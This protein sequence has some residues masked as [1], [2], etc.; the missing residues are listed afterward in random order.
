[1]RIDCIT[2]R[3]KMIPLLCINNQTP[4]I[5]HFTNA[6][7]SESSPLRY[8]RIAVVV[9]ESKMANARAPDC[10]LF[11]I[12]CWIFRSFVQ[13]TIQKEKTPHRRDESVLL[14]QSV[15]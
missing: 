2:N 7:V 1:M 9:L 13:V 11:G 15:A 12:K 5:H 10:L 14:R 6:G 3:V 8:W 4:C